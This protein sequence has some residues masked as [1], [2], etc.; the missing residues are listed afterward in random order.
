MTARF[1]ADLLSR[2]AEEASRL[3]ALVYLDEA[4]RAQRRLGDPLD[5]EALHDFR[6]GLR[7]LRSCT[8]AYRPQ[9][10]GSVS[11]RMRRRLRDLTRATNP[12]RDTEVQLA[13]L[14]QQT[15]RLGPGDTQGLAWLTGRLEGQKHEALE[16]ITND[17]AR[18]FTKVATRLRP[19]LQSF[20]VEV[21]TGRG[22]D[23]PSF[24]KVT[25]GLIQTQGQRLAEKLSAVRSQDDV[26]EAHA[27]RIAAKRLRYVLE[28]LSRRVPGA[29]GLVQR[30][31]E[32]QDILGHLRDRHVLADEIAASLTGLARG[33]SSQPS[34][35]EIGLTSLR[36]LAAAD[37]GAMFAEFQ[38]RWAT[39]T[40]ARFFHQANEL[41]RRLMEPEGQLTDV[42]GPPDPLAQHSVDPDISE[43]KEIREGRVLAWKSS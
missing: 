42:A 31:K 29:K 36:Q 12:G 26:A 16:L 33:T 19:R 35:A 22:Q 41:G 18:R 3:V 9:L 38:A 14:E 4:G 37:A 10:K 17:L 27:A 5:A 23:R 8:R 7:R 30:L 20:R 6:V 2:S 39:G 40:A 43:R 28:P 24:G 34:A 13:W 15:T 32:L 1:P 11:R 21:R 25:G